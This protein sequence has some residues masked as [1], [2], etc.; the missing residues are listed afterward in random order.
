MT[1]TRVA[2]LLYKAGRD[3]AVFMLPFFLLHLCGL[4]IPEASAKVIL[5]TVYA[6]ALLWHGRFDA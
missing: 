3:T 2:R 5:A 4:A 1:R 6:I